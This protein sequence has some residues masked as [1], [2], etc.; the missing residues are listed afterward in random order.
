MSA[1]FQ[2]E[3]E[4]PTVSPWGALFRVVTEPG[5]TFERL[6]ER[7]PIMPGYLF[8]MLGILVVSAATW[9]A[10]L[11]VAEDQLAKMAA[12]GQATGGGS[13]TFIVI[14]GVVALL[15]APWL[16]GLFTSLLGLLAGQFQGGGVHFGAY[17]GMIGY[18]RV[19]LMLGAFVQGL[20]TLLAKSPQE[21]SKLS[22][23]LAA[24]LP[25]DA[26]NTLRVFMQSINPFD[27]WY[28]VLL[29]MGF[30]ALHKKK[31]ARGITF[32]AL[33]YVLGLGMTMLTAGL[34]KM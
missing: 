27:I 16:A 24:F 26:S 19:P 31:P 20:M 12:A 9:S 30:A 21:A 3:K 8:Q 33:V 14:T 15:I 2:L 23:S 11:A 5:L 4:K 28:Y 25:A 18:A 7:P 10:M 32:A 17:F 34:S 1:Q 22:L 13:A 6:G 29:A